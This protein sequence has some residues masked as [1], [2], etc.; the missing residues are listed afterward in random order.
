[1]VVG[2]LVTKGGGI[3]AS[4]P[5]VTI[6]GGRI[7]GRDATA[8]AYLAHGQVAYVQ[9][10]DGGSGY[11]TPIAVRVAPGGT[12][13]NTVPIWAPAG[14][15]KSSARD[16]ANLAQAAL[17]HSVI[18]GVKIPLAIVNAFQLAE[19]PFACEGT[20]P[21]LTN[22]KCTTVESGLAWDILKETPTNVYKIGD[23][24]GYASVI[25]LL[26]QQ[27]A[28]VV[29]LVNSWSPTQRTYVNL[30]PVLGFNII[31]A[32]YFTGIIK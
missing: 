30:A 9:V 8:T 28:A 5:Q 10:T 13:T 31:N 22:P 24:P 17:G 32:L 26:P 3:Y 16:L 1:V 14:A 29:V 2:V 21:S 11:V 15:L 27:N 6:S 18:D 7:G 20:S 25:T 12:L 23:L 4:A 19:T